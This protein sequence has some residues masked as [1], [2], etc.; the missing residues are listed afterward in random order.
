[1]NLSTE[2]TVQAS[3]SPPAHGRRSRSGDPGLLLQR[4]RDGVDWR[5]WQR[6]FHRSVAHGG[7]SSFRGDLRPATWAFH[8]AVL[9][10][11]P[12]FSSGEAHTVCSRYVAGQIGHEPQ[13]L[14]LREGQRQGGRQVVELGADLPWP[15]PHH[16]SP[17]PHVVVD[18]PELLPGLLDGPCF[19]PVSV[20]TGEARWRAIKAIAHHQT[21][22][23]Q[24][25][26]GRELPDQILIAAGTA[27]ESSGPRT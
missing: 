15:A 8:L 18:P 17:D 3:R 1:M 5:R 7:L 11:I 24:A 20:S 9:C 6:L 23:V 27:R 21:G 26:P 22:P 2:S 10:S 16:W 12:A 19:G 25:G 14:A 13:L 4:L